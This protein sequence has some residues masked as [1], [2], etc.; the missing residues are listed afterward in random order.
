MAVRYCLKVACLDPVFEFAFQYW[1]S[2][3]KFYVLRSNT[4]SSRSR[5]E[6]L[7]FKAI[8]DSLSRAQ[9]FRDEFPWN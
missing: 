1:E 2:A 3:G 6:M 7:L 8:P 5:L 4:R 9:V